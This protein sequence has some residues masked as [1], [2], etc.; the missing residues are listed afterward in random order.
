MTHFSYYDKHGNIRAFIEGK[1]CFVKDLYINQEY[2][3]TGKGREFMEILY[4]WLRA[5]EINVVELRSTEEAK[6]FYLKLDFINI[7][8]NI[9]RKYLR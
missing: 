6:G 2:R 1:K 3:N 9:Y 8:E 5:K 4:D 7:R